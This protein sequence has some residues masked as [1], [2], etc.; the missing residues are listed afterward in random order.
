ML[1]P[2]RFYVDALLSVGNIA[3]VA[4]NVPRPY[5]CNMSFSLQ[6]RTTT[7]LLTAKQLKDMGHMGDAWG[8]WLR[9]S[10]PRFGWGQICHWHRIDR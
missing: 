1:G 4:Q 3:C 6:P 2:M 5:V 7:P 8:C 9:L 10:V